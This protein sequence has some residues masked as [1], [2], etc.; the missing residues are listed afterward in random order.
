[1]DYKNSRSAKEKEWIEDYFM[2]L[3]AYSLSHNEM[4]GTD[5]RKGVVM[6]ATRDARYQEFIIEGDEFIKYQVMWLEK[7]DVYYS[8]PEISINTP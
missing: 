7:V 2:Q 5:I 6:V 3:A 1:M 8:L 4:Y